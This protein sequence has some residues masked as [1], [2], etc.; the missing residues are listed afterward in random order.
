MSLT[1]EVELYQL[2]K[3]PAIQKH[4]PH[5]MGDKEFCDRATGHCSNTTACDDCNVYQS[6][7][8]VQ[9]YESMFKKD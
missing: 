3:K 1:D 5:F 2:S 6:M 7:I 4:H 8:E 9:K